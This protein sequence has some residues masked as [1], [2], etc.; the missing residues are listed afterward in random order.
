MGLP[1]RDTNALGVESRSLSPH[2]PQLWP[3]SGLQVSEGGP[4]LGPHAACSPERAQ[5]TRRH[6]AGLEWAG[7]HLKGLEAG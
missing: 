7:Q 3:T 1:S 4:W 2:P 6:L 5:G